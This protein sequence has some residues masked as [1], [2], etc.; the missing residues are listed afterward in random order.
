MIKATNPFSIA[1]L[2]L[3]WMIAATDEFQSRI[4]VT[5]AEKAMDHVYG[6][7]IRD[8][9]DTVRPAAL[10]GFG[11]EFSMDEVAGGSRLASVI[12]STL[13]VDLLMDTAPDYF[14][15]AEGAELDF[16]NFWGGVLCQIQ[17]ISMQDDPVSPDGNS[18]LFIQNIEPI[19][20]PSEVPAELWGTLGRW[21]AIRFR[22]EWG[23]V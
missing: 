11:D 7:A 6:H 22:V 14:S 17:Q 9:V 4:G 12:R 10:V 20:V 5:S 19:T 21:W 2:E 16:M 13:F 15:D 1:Y 23:G 18:S 3:K 8:A